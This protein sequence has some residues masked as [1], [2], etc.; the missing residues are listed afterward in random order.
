[1]VWV[2]PSPCKYSSTRVLTPWRAALIPAL[3]PAVPPPTTTTSYSPI[4]GME[5]PAKV[6]F[7]L[8]VSLVGVVE[9]LTAP[10]ILYD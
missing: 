2:P 4:T 3:A 9:I 7:L 1:M 6:R 8:E 10:L 5:E